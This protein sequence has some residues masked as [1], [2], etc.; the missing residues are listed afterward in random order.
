[1]PDQKPSK[2][3]EL[4]E[5]FSVEERRIVL[6]AAKLDAEKVALFL[7]I[8]G[9]EAGGEPDRRA[10]SG[11]SL[12]EAL[13]ASFGNELRG[14]ILNM[15]GS[16]AVLDMMAEATLTIG[17]AGFSNDLKRPRARADALGQEGFSQLIYYTLAQM[18]RH[19]PE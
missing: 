11:S 9:A 3:R 8:F 17:H 2:H 6:E 15:Q 19:I 4:L 1:M 12:Y 7:R 16:K 5:F 13:N 14:H 10:N 18:L